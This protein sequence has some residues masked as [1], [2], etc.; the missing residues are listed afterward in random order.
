[1]RRPSLFFYI[2][3]SILLLYHDLLYLSVWIIFAS[4]LV[5]FLVRK[6][7][8][9]TL[10][11]NAPPKNAAVL[12]TGT[13]SGFGR[14][15]ALHL[16]QMGFLVFAG[17][18]NKDDGASLVDEANKSDNNARCSA[19]IRPIIL[20]VTKREHIEDA[21]L[22][23]R[24]VLEKEDRQLF[25]LVNNAGIH[26]MDPIEIVDEQKLRK[27]FDVNVFGAVAVTQ[28]FLPFLREF[29]E[30]RKCEQHTLPNQH[31]HL[32]KTIYPPLRRNAM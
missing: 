6:Y 9:E 4:I 10:L 5:A 13:S 31:L 16:S 22:S 3:L 19:L 21:V 32:I 8:F 18:R 14:A 29:N 20:D 15:F 17:V 26:I 25:A 28:A 11:Q 7:V 24:S 12:I 30:Q 27:G 2:A 1:M 23:V